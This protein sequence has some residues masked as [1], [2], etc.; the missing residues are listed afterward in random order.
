MTTIPPTAAI[1]AVMLGE[2]P[3]LPAHRDHGTVTRE[4]LARMLA[5]ALVRDEA[6]RMEAA[7]SAEREAADAAKPAAE[8]NEHRVTLLRSEIGP[9]LWRNPAAVP[10]GT[11]PTIAF[12]ARNALANADRDKVWQVACMTE[13]ELCRLK[14][15]GRLTVNTIKRWLAS[16]GLSLGMAA[17]PDVI[18]ARRAK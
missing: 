6:E 16:L 1:L 17:D 18:A 7:E 12:R 2:L 11:K 13:A 4:E 14:N 10:D 9:F 5:H 15:C 3:K 8:G